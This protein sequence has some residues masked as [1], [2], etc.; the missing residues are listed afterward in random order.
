MACLSYF[1]S[2]VSYQGMSVPRLE[3]IGTKRNIIQ[4]Q[5]D[6][7][8]YRG[9]YADQLSNIQS[10]AIHLTRKNMSV[11]RQRP[12]TATALNRP[13][14]GNNNLNHQQQRV[15]PPGSLQE[16]R[17]SRA[18]SQLSQQATPFSYLNEMAL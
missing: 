12:L 17:K 14:S 8:E 5:L 15:I 4:T 3:L 13:L 11:T 18:A 7:F 16:M 2:Q 9:L 6:N 1:P 10:Q